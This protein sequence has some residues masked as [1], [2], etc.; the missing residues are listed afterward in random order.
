MTPEQE[1]RI[2]FLAEK[3]I[4]E[5]LNE[6]ETQELQELVTSNED[7]ALIFSEY[8]QGHA[9]LTL[10]ADHLPQ[11]SQLELNE[12]KKFPWSWLVA[13]AATLFFSFIFTEMRAP[14]SLE[15]FA[16]IESSA[17]ANWGEC[18]LPTVVGGELGAGKLQINEGLATLV[19]KS[20]AKVTLEGPAT[21]EIIDS[22][23]TRLHS[24]IVVSD[25]P[26]SAHGFTIY[27]P[28]AT[29]VDH[30]TRFL[31]QVTDDG[32]TTVLDV[33]EGEVE[34]IHDNKSERFKTGQIAKT[35]SEGFEKDGDLRHEL[36]ITE[37]GI[38]PLSTN[39]LRVST[40]YGDGRDGTAHD[41][42]PD[43]HFNAG[44]IMIKHSD[45]YLRKGFAG[46]DLKFL[47]TS[48][49]K[50]VK[51]NFN[52]VFSGYGSVALTQRS[53]FT[54]YGVI[55]DSTD[56]WPQGYMALSKSPAYKEGITAI[57]LEKAVKVGTFEISRGEITGNRSLSSPELLNLVKMDGNKFI[58][59]VFICDTPAINAN[60]G[61]L[62]YSIAGKLHPTAQAP[63][64]HIELE[65]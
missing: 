28:T 27:T 40:S 20:G 29:A 32:K 54:V 47:D 52:L 21:F 19:F 16:K 5:A 43:F 17:F 13:A 3:L 6:L 22:M 18:T 14:K 33:L 63:A 8:M 53:T 25:I 64:L 48:K 10:D 37:R 61:A 49:V 56:T 62:I 9:M 30:G 58:T 4:E 11:S 7:A 15:T 44:D 36:Y 41:F 2:Q 38:K 65:K 35:S 12:P 42:D 57:D 23:Q 55:D 39:M 60:T 31:T 1:E 46:F 34:L 51:L 24:G 59:L 50:D 26:E 45:K